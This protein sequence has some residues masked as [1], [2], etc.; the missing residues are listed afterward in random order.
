M[1][2]TL[3]QISLIAVK[4]KVWGLSEG[5]VLSRWLGTF[6]ADSEDIRNAEQRLGV[7]LPEDYKQ[8]LSITNGFFTPCD[9]TEPTF[10]RVTNIDLLKNVEPFLLD[11]WNQDELKDVGQ[12]LN[13]AIIIAGL[14][15][16]QFFLLIPP[17]D[18]VDIWQYWKFA[19]WIPGEHRFD[20]LQS[21]F[22]SVLD[23]MSSQ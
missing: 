9:A 17:G 16:E 11:V 8:F 4:Q 15:D 1:K 13:R 22:D 5:H 14:N 2:E 20:N 21:Y 18:D 3:K 23:F 12:Q 10:E 6:P 7:E 19:S